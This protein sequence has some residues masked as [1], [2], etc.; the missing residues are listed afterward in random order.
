LQDVALAPRKRTYWDGLSAQSP[1]IARAPSGEWLLYYIGTTLEEQPAVCNGSASRSA[2][3]GVNRSIARLA[4]EQL[5]QRIGL[6]TAVSPNGP[7]TRLDSPIVGPGPAGSWDDLFTAD[8]A[9]YVFENSSCLLIYKARGLETGGMFHGVA[10]ADHWSGPYRKF[11]EASPMQ[12]DHSCEDPYLFREPGGLFRIIWHCGCGHK[13]GSSVDGIVWDTT[14]PVQYQ[15]WCNTNFTDGT[16]AR[17]Y[18]RE[19]P[20]LILDRA[21]LPT[22]L[23]TGVVPVSG[24][25]TWTTVCPLG[26]DPE[27][28][29]DSA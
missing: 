8:M 7:W 1:A 29:P 20:Q 13:I 9:P 5:N 14:A 2:A 12:L 24:D 28:E 11:T 17:F 19:R 21:G 26:P 16:P 25:P 18:R 27:T 22:H 10:F 3:Q 6:A 23:S 4:P 15:G